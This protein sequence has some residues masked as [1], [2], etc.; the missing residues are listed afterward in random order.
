MLQL[1]TSLLN[2]NNQQ[3]VMNQM[4]PPGPFDQMMFP[5]SPQSF[6]QGNVQ[7][8]GLLNSIFKR[9]NQSNIDSQGG[10]P[11]VPSQYPGNP[12][13][14]PQNFG[15]FMNQL[16]SQGIENVTT[17][18]TTNSGLTGTLNNVQ[19]ALK[20]VEKTAP[21][22]RQYGPMVKNMPAMLK[23]LKEF[24]NMDED[25]GSGEETNESSE[26][27]E[28]STNDQSDNDTE[29]PNNTR[30]SNVQTTSREPQNNHK[31][32]EPSKPKLYI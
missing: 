27:T 4:P 3:N 2:K 8:K 12:G 21:I 22:I 17:N 32:D 18:S 7:S 24:N 10:F 13:Q 14:W 5:R 25:E 30:S 20:M 9:G 23:M 29:K 15:P 28:L 11:N 31:K 16:P 1:L 6:Q 26:K 19:S